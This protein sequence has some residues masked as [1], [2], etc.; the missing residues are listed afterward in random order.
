MPTDPSRFST[1]SFALSPPARPGHCSVCG[2]TSINDPCSLCG[3]E[4]DRRAA[5]ARTRAER[6][7]VKLGL[8]IDTR[9]LA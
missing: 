6:E 8:S 2:L 4:D 7:R 3:L 9:D 5:K 1:R